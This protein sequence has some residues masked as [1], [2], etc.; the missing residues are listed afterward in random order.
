MITIILQHKNYYDPPILY[1]YYHLWEH[2]FVG[3]LTEKMSQYEVRI[4]GEASKDR[5]ILIIDGKNLETNFVSDKELDSVVYN[6][7]TFIPKI[8]DVEKVVSENIQ[9]SK[10]DWDSYETS[11]DFKRNPLV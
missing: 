3:I 10:K 9:V 4:L 8:E 11:W 6:F 5:T 7:K 2:I 1:S